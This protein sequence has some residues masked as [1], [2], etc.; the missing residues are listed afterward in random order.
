MSLFALRAS[1]E[2]LPPMA[3]GKI[4]SYPEFLSPRTT[5]EPERSFDQWL[6]LGVGLASHQYGADWQEAFETG[7]VQG[8][9]WRGPGGTSETLLSGLLFPSC[10][11]VGRRYPLAVAVGVPRALVAHAPHVLPLAFGDFLE[12]AH[13]ATSDFGELQPADLVAR[14]ATLGPPSE[15]D[16]TSAIADYDAWCRSTRPEEAWSAIFED[17]DPG[18]SLPILYAL[19]SATEAVR[20]V[21]QPA[22]GVS[23]R[24]PLGR[25]GPAS[26]TLW[27]D[28]IRRL[29]RWTRTVPTTFWA[30]NQGSLVV[31]LGDAPPGVLSAL[32]Y[33]GSEHVYDLTVPPTAATEGSVLSV[34][35]RMS[36]LL[37]SLGP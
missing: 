36:D 19:G 3:K 34:G 2:F 18:R 17:G 14:L 6:E 26:A 25:G 12:R 28:V 22:A 1:P 13:H 33:Q 31:S 37:A 23:L 30:V 8:F 32:W 16:V 11:A 27:L 21:E 10:D 29:S 15:E 20:G 7:G 35:S 4:P 9:V 5:R 24:L